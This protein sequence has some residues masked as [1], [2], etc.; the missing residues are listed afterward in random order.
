MRGPTVEIATRG[1]EAWS[2]WHHSWRMG[3]S[4]LRLQPTLADLAA[5]VTCGQF[6]NAAD[7]RKASRENTAITNI[8]KT[9]TRTCSRAK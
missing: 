5:E 6:K 8:A 3:H 1:G 7:T 2:K 4:N 9:H